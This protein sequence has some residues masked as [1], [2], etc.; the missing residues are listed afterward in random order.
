M[1]V[2]GRQKKM[3]L[4]IFNHAM[5]NLPSLVLFYYAVAMGRMVL[6][7]TILFELSKKT[8]KNKYFI[9]FSYRFFFFSH[10]RNRNSL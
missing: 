8:W 10:N 1:P 6:S 3:L 2:L 4:D 9:H 5:P 7:T